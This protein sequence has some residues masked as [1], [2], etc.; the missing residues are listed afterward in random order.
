MRSYPPFLEKAAT[1]VVNDVLYATKL[2]ESTFYRETTEPFLQQLSTGSQ[3]DLDACVD[4]CAFTAKDGVILLELKDFYD[5]ADDFK[6]ILKGSAFVITCLK[7]LAGSIMTIQSIIKENENITNP[8]SL[9][10]FD[11][12]KHSFIHFHYH[13]R[14]PKKYTEQEQKNFRIN[15]YNYLLKANKKTEGNNRNKIG[16]IALFKV[17]LGNSLT[18]KYFSIT[19]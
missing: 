10:D 16:D 2:D 15:L 5:S 7:K 11:L 19:Y 17:H 18:E 8:K 9:F 1:V 4:V 12:Q 14:P 13:I 3:L 6:N